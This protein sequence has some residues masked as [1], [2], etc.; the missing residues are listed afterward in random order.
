MYSLPADDKP[1]EITNEQKA[2]AVKLIIV[3][4]PITICPTRRRVQLYPGN[5]SAGHNYG[6]N[7]TGMAAR[8]DYAMNSGTNNPEVCGGPGSLAVG[9]AWPECG[10]L[11]E[12]ERKPCENCWP[13]LRTWTG[14]GYQRSRIAPAHVRDGTSN[15]ILLGEKYINSD[16]YYGRCVATGS[17]DGG[18]NENMYSGWNNDMYRSTSAAPRQDRP[19]AAASYY[20]GSAHAGACNFA[21]ADGSVRSISYSINPVTFRYLGTRSSGDVVDASEL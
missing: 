21:L 12:P 4:L 5:S 13:D 1:D 16:C 10:D 20:F 14:L 19:G 3:P 7:S 9:E 2:G 18:D 15:T 6:A 8:C 11:P 17:V